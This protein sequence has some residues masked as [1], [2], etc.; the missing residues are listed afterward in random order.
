MAKS[1]NWTPAEIETAKA[2]RSQG[3]TVTE[4]GA[5]LNRSPGGVQLKLT[6]MGVQMPA[7]HMAALQV[8]NAERARSC[9][10]YGEK[11]RANLR[12]AF[13][14]ERRAAAGALATRLRIWEMGVPARSDEC[15]RRSAVKAT[16][17]FSAK[18]TGWCPP[19]M[20][21]EYREW[22]AKGLYPAAEARR[23][24]T[25]E[26]VKQ[27]RR[28]L[29]EIAEVAKPLAEEQRRHHN[30]LEG[31]IERIKAG[32]ARV[33]PTF[34]PGRMVSDDRSLIGN[35]SAMAAA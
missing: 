18:R 17:A 15:R 19:H 24:L 9:E 6:K 2:M 4:I 1:P 32:T 7:E 8:R 20:L 10:A 16:A 5:V 27:L 26:W 3:A 29:R 21:G 33:V 25:D 12:A 28:A 11:R 31:Q 35:S 22:V 14:D 30:S 13:T 23:M 34:K